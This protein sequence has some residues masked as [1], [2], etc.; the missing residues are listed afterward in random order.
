MGHNDVGQDYMTEHKLISAAAA[1]ELGCIN[2]HREKVDCYNFV[3]T[4]DEINL[5]LD[6][7]SQV[8]YDNDDKDDKDD[9]DDNDDSKDDNEI[10]VMTLTMK[11]VSASTIE[12]R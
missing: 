9:T 8:M 1:K 3:D 5:S 12:G 10:I 11:L 2:N 7:R 6:H 4:R